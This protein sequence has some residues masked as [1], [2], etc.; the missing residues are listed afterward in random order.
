MD[1]LS[2]V[3]RDL[4]LDSTVF[5]V[6]EMRAPWGV[7]KPPH[8]GAPFHVVTEGRCWVQ[9]ELESPIEMRTGDLV[10]VPHGEGHKLLSSPD[11]PSEPISTV[12]ARHGVYRKW[13]PG[14]RPGRPLEI[15]LG[16]TEGELA[17]V[18]SGVFA[19]QDRRRNPVLET[20]PRLIH[21][22]GEHGRASPSLEAA[23]RL[24]VDEA[25]SQAPGATS[26]VERV[27]DI[28]FVQ[29]V[30]AHIQSSKGGGGG[31]LRGLADPK[32]GLTLSLIHA[33]PA[34]P[35]TIELLARE[36]G[37]SR[38]VFA[39]RFRE[40]VGETVMAYVT[41]RRMHIAAGLLHGGADSLAQIAQRVG[42]ESDVSFSK[43]FR[44]WSGEPPGSY[45]RR[46]KSHES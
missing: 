7:Q 6:F 24:L 25:F 31:W 40:L 22:P 18:V 16:S 14:M 29:A 23:L 30:R 39:E 46:M 45:R 41:G 11:A 8:E 44:A 4:H 28:L 36:V 34:V 26:V 15:S 2:D 12:L 5:C 21:V 35:W 42:Y 38:T 1:P 33:Q 17:R 13:T 10:V 37:L 9:F 27:A 20:L 43:A 19:F 32:I 3:L